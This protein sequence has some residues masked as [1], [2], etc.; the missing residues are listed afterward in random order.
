MKQKRKK[1]DCTFKK[2][3]VLLSYERNSVGKL[4]KELKL[5]R[6]ALTQWR[7][8]HKKNGLESFQED[9]DLQLNHEKRKNYYLEIK[10]KQSDL[11]LE[12]LKSAGQYLSLAKPK[13]FNLIEDN[14][15]TY[16]INLMCLALS[17]DRSNYYKWKN[18]ILTKVEKRKI[19]LKQEISNIFYAAKCRYGSTRI[20]VVLQNSGLK[21]STKTVKKYMR[22]MG[23]SNHVKKN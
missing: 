1:Y 17:A 3:A 14:E 13:I 8:E 12:F 9:Y 15:K 21:T 18:K 6:G 16:S 22:E 4:E 19:L 23:L 7:R 5:Y 20:T 10:I 2:K 11:K